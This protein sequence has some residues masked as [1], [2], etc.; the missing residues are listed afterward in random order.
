M[1]LPVRLG[2]DVVLGNPQVAVKGPYAVAA[3]AGRH[4]DVSPDGKRFLL[5]MDAETAT[6]AK[7]AP[8]EI[9]LVL[10]WAEE[11]KAKVPAGK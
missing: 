6:G 1:A 11:L 3:N 4:Y 7:P 9:H 2:A 5:L 10:N 8:P